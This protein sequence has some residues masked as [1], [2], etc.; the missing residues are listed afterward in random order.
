MSQSCFQFVTVPLEEYLKELSSAQVQASSRTP[1]SNYNCFHHLPC[2]SPFV[3]SFPPPSFSQVWGGE[4][5]LVALSRLYGRSIV[6]YSQQDRGNS[7]HERIIAVRAEEGRNVDALEKPVSA[8]KAL[9][10][11]AHA[12]VLCVC[13]KFYP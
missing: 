10:V 2:L 13:V 5:E 11:R 4:I 3:Y 8:D 9:Y 1:L 12:C 6:V 7:V